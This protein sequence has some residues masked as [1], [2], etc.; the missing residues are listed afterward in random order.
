MQQALS[1][2]VA[3]KLEVMEV[4]KHLTLIFIAALLCENCDFNALRDGPNGADIDAVSKGSIVEHV[5]GIHL[6]L[7]EKYQEKSMRSG[8]LQC[9][10]MLLHP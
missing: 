7:Y 6:K 9:M 1:K 10:G 4:K 2:P 5:Y 3:K 8:V